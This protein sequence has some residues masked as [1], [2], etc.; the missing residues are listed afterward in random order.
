MEGKEQEALDYIY[1]RSFL[2]KKR[3]G[4]HTPLHRQI[5]AC[6]APAKLLHSC[7]TLC[8][9]MDCSPSGSSVHGILQTRKLE[10]AAMPSS[11][12]SS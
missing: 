1:N 11:R 10:S 2:F 6:L 7:P 8:N 5:P 4:A 3:T 9:S 12:E